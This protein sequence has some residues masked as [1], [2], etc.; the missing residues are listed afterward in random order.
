LSS[1]LSISD[2]QETQHGNIIVIIACYSRTISTVL[3]YFF[4]I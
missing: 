2:F 4:T 1:F 3:N